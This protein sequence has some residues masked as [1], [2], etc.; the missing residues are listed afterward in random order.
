MKTALLGRLVAAALLGTMAHVLAAP[1]A[2][3]ATDADVSPTPVR[4]GSRITVTATCSDKV[5]AATISAATLGGASNIA[6]TKQAQGR[7]TVVLTVPEGTH[8][9]T[10]DLGGT[11]GDGKGFTAKVVVWG[12]TRPTGAAPAAGPTGAP[13]AGPTGTRAAGPT[14]GPGARWPTGAPAAGGGAAMAGPN[15]NTL[16]AA[17]G[18]LAAAVVGGVLLLRRRRSDAPRA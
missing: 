7:F 15:L 4:P 13:A 11:C 18:M 6:M 5:S 1:V 3:S 16:L 8:A 12:A 2:A 9:G 10:Y 17:V 14:G